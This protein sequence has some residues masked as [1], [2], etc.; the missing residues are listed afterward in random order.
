MRRYYLIVDVMNL[1]RFASSFFKLTGNESSQNERTINVDKKQREELMETARRELP[2]T[3]SLP[4]SYESLRAL[5]HDRTIEQQTIII[6]RMIKCNHS[7][8]AESNKEGLRSLFIYLLQYFND[9]SSDCTSEESVVF[10][11]RVFRNLVPHV[12]DLCQFDAKN[13]CD[14]MISVLKEKHDEFDDSC[15]YPGL[16]VLLF[17]EL[18][19]FL[20]PTSD[21]RH[22]VTTPAIVFIDQMLTKCKVRD[23][24]DVTYGL[25][26]VTL[27][28]KVSII[29]FGFLI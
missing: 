23:R 17:L 14:A 8:L 27:T 2:Y 7:R 22:S 20:F 16:D 21:F 12:F 19:G 11:F 5:L 3:F 29:Q 28:L 10:C 6:E 1:C 15:K 4:D 18:V 26:L 25:F 24:R 13:S 9:L